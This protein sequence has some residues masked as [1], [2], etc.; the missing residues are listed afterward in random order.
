MND[1]RTLLHF[2][3]SEGHTDLALFLLSS[4]C[5]PLDLNVQDATEEGDSPLSRLCL[6]KHPETLEAVL[7]YAAAAGLKVNLS[8][9]NKENNSLIH[10]CVQAQDAQSIKV[11]LGFSSLGF[12]RGQNIKTIPSFNQTLDFKVE[13]T[14]VGCALLYAVLDSSPAGIAVAK[15]LI[16]DVGPPDVDLNQVNKIDA[17]APIVM[18][19]NIGN[20]EVVKLLVENRADLSLQSSEGWSVLHF[21]A[22]SGNA[23][24]VKYLVQSDMCKGKI[25]PNQYNND[26]NTALAIAR[27]KKHDDIVDVLTPLTTAP[28]ADA[29]LLKKR[30]LERT[31][32][33]EVEKKKKRRDRN[34]KQ[35]AVTVSEEDKA[36]ALQLKD[37]GNQLFAKEDWEGAKEKY[38]EAIKL[39]PTNH[40]FYSNRSACWASLK[41]GPKALEDAQKCRDLAPKWAKSFWRL[42]EALMLVGDPM[43]AVMVFW[44]GLQLEPG[45]VD[46][47]RAFAEATDVAKK[48]HQQQE[49]KK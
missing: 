26:G 1:C 2:A 15:L 8:L 21:A 37:E 5:G 28:E 11:L 32:E 44:E 33:K 27:A 18:A 29:F 30:E 47:Q 41:D 19:C 9:V 17:G 3:L 22:D 43:E 13:D 35:P 10:H 42:G 16:S 49:P 6:S 38:N 4:T 40:V 14:S 12:P 39:D 24:I 25:D 45:N 36:K 48:K 7:N 23:E 46:F 31:Q 34:K 20:L